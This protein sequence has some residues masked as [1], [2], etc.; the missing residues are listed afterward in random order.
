MNHCQQF[1]LTGDTDQQESIFILR[2]LHVRQQN[3]FL[4]SK[5]RGRFIKR[6]PVLLNIESCLRIVPL[7]DQ[8]SDFNSLHA[9]TPASISARG[10]SGFSFCNSRKIS[11][12]RS[13]CTFGTTIFTSTIWSPR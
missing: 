10:S 3:A 1:A 8:S 6:N 5:Y 9:H 7:E 11:F 4:V 12:D 13:S 2:M